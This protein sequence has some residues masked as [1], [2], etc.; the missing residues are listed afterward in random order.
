MELERSN[1]GAVQIDIRHHTGPRGVSAES[2]RVESVRIKVP[3]EVIVLFSPLEEVKDGDDD[4]EDGD[5]ASD[6]T[7]GDGSGVRG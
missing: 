2:F 4:G 5:G 6:D 3:V 7:A 1:L